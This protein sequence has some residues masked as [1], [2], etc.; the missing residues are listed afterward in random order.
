MT[1][2]VLSNQI[3][4]TIIRQTISK[5][6][7]VISFLW[8][9]VLL[10]ISLFVMTLGVALCVRSN[11]GSSVISTIPFVFTIAGENVLAPDWTIGQYT[12]IMNFI[13]VGFQILLLRK[14]FDKMQLFQLVIGFL[15]GFLLDVNMTLTSSM[16]YDSL[17]PRI[18]EQLIGCTILGLGIAFEIRCGSV[19]MPGEGITVA[20]SRVTTIPFAKAKIIIDCILVALAVMFGYVYFSQ[21]LWNVVG[22]GTLFAM[23]YVGLVVKILNPHL[24]WFDRV[25]CYRPGFRRYLYGLARFIYRKN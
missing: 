3:S 8:Q 2:F 12:Y 25:V 24:D 20:F 5:K 9:H 1:K 23:I 11:L 14:R 18:L 10:T 22:P 19:T 17:L 6:E 4:M 15:F 16:T 7:R 13:L 21:W